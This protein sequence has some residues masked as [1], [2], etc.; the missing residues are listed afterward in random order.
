MG[1]FGLVSAAEHQRR[2][3]AAVAE[4]ERLLGEARGSRHAA[5]EFIKRIGEDLN[6]A[7]AEIRRLTDIIVELKRG[8]HEVSRPV[9]QVWEPYTT[10]EADAAR[11]AQ[12]RESHEQSPTTDGGPHSGY[13]EQMELERAAQQALESEIEEL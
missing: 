3:K 7:R 5:E 8:G 9:G 13:L 1:L 12:L 6:E 10:T 4:S 11:A 2:I